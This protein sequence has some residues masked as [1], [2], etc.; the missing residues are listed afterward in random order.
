MVSKLQLISSE[1]VAA[2][3]TAGGWEDRT[4]DSDDDFEFRLQYA[5]DISFYVGLGP[6]FHAGSVRFYPNL[7]VQHLTTSR[8]VVEFLGLQPSAGDSLCSIGV[9]LADIL[10]RND[11]SVA[12]FQR[13]RIA[14][15]EEA[16]PV[17]EDIY[18]DVV[19]FGIPSLVR[20][21]HLTG[22][23]ADCKLRFDISRCR[24]ISLL[25]AVLPAGGRRLKAPCVSTPT[26]RVDSK[27]V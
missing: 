8:L 19:E 12:P 15:P 3:F 13:W 23:L 10:D 14:S 4:V 5:D 20:S 16:R 24:A 17:V 7:G 25:R 9:G 6:S 22:L 18:S 21:V 1:Q 11:T 2:V 27:G 26:R